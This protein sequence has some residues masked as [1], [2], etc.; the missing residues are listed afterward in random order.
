LPRT[1]RIDSALASASASVKRALDARA[2]FDD[3]AAATELAGAER[4]LV[5][6][7]PGTK[8]RAALAEVNLEIARMHWA[9]DPGRALLH[10]GTARVL[11]PDLTSLDPAK[12][13][14][15]EIKLFERAATGGGT[16]MARIT[17]SFDG[18]EV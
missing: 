8:V 11:R 18:A 3:T 6:V 14:P 9:S 10:F 7:E 1:S 12:F 5:D 17:T 15:G 16:G 2:R 13:S 4:A